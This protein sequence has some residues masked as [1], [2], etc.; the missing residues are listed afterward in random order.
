MCWKTFHTIRKF[1]PPSSSPLTFHTIRKF[2]R[3]TGSENPPD[4]LGKNLEF[5][6]L[7]LSYHP[8]QILRRWVRVLD[9]Q[10]STPFP[11]WVLDVKAQIL[12][13]HFFVDVTKRG[14][15][16]INSFLN[17]A[18]MNEGKYLRINNVP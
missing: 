16:R 14:S 12:R 6:T 1:L 8:V 10:F 3:F 18:Y 11:P 2:L 4:P 9:G 17:N 7:I 13:K 5:F 15:Y